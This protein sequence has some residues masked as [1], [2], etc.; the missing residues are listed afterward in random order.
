MLTICIRSRGTFDAAMQRKDGRNRKRERDGRL[1]L[2]EPLRRVNSLTRQARMKPCSSEAAQ[3]T[4]L[5]IDSPPCVHLATI[6]VLI[7]CV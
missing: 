6:L 1:A 2:R 3:P 5:S 7:A 4:A